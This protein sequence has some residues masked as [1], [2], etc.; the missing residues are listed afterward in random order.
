MVFVQLVLETTRIVRPPN[1]DTIKT[2][3]KNENTVTHWSRSETLQDILTGDVRCAEEGGV[4]RNTDRAAEAELLVLARQDQQCVTV[5]L[6]LQ[7]CQAG[8]PLAQRF[9][10][11]TQTNH[12]YDSTHFLSVFYKSC[13][14]YT[15]LQNNNYSFKI[16]KNT[17][18]SII[19]HL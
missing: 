6:S 9:T 14:H 3:Q 7:Q 18:F 2:K 13:C 11:S 5:L 17:F 19:M 10:L 12:F 1:Y 4:V 16:I 8:Q 15:V